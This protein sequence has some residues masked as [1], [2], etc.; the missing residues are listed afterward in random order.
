M[1][2]AASIVF[3]MHR[4]QEYT[5]IKSVEPLPKCVQLAWHPSTRQIA[6]AETSSHVH[7]CN[8]SVPSGRKGAQSA[9]NLETELLLW[10]DIQQQVRT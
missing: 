9:V 2:D 7:V 5:G 3:L 6:V 1:S 8:A 10:H 4:L